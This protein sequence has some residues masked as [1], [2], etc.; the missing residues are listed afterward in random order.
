MLRL[1]QQHV[2]VVA[3]RDELVLQDAIGVLP[4]QE[5]FHHA[6][7]LRPQAQEA[8]ARLRQ[9]RRGVVRD[10]ARPEDG[11]ANGPRH[12][13]RVA[14]ARGQVAETRDGLG[15]PHPPG[16]LDPP[17][18]EGSDVEQGPRLEVGAGNPG[19]GQGLWQI[20][21]VVVG[22]P[23][24][25][26]EE[27]HPLG[28]GL[29]GLPDAG[30]IGERLERFDPDPPLDRPRLQEE[31]RPDFVEL[32]SSKSVSV[33]DPRTTPWPRFRDLSRKHRPLCALKDWDTAI[34]ALAPS[35]VRPKP[36]G[37][38]GRDRTTYKMWRI[39]GFV[40]EMEQENVAP[41]P[42]LGSGRRG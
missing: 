15:R 37:P 30:G 35:P 6:R 10:L 25:A 11:P 16:D 9:P 8:P 32:Q 31:Q 7:E 2:A 29:E 34:P 18:D 4:A 23:P 17:F 26:P 19:G 20:G 12:L 33:H 41:A 39:N 42:A 22:L 28:R 38:Q 5:A 24:E 13:A 21:Q 36:T 3:G 40:K 14:D 1:E 27:R